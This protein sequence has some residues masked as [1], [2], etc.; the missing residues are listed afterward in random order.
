MNFQAFLVEWRALWG[1][2]RTMHLRPLLSYLNVNQ[3]IEYN[4]WFKVVDKYSAHCSLHLNFYRSKHFSRF[5]RS[6]GGGLNDQ[7]MSNKSACVMGGNMFAG[8]LF[9]NTEQCKNL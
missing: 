8:C 9:T 2:N 3:C 5:K 7:N 4:Q 6:S 1:Y